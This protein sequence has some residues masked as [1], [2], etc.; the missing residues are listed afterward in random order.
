MVRGEIGIVNSQD[1]SE[2]GIGPRRSILEA[3]GAEELAMVGGASRTDMRKAE[4]L[5]IMKF[6]LPS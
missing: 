4:R 1:V 3:P 5:P 6:S 2:F